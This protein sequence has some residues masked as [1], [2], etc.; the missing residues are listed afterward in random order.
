MI[1][2]APTTPT[3]GKNRREGP[4]KRPN[5][6]TTLEDE[7]LESLLGS[8]SNSNS[9]TLIVPKKT[10]KKMKV[11][12]ASVSDLEDSNI[13]PLLSIR[14]LKKR[15]PGPDTTRSGRR[16]TRGKTV[17]ISRESTR[18]KTVPTSKRLLKVLPKKQAPK[19]NKCP[20]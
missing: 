18:K 11:S 10:L 15:V 13:N 7:G 6:P 2:S 4:N 16:D 1:R 14:A 9:K 20:F 12:K 19:K 3:K 8:N 5:T 17:P